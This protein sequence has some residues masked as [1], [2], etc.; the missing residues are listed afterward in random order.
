[1]IDLVFLLVFGLGLTGILAMAAAW[2]D[3]RLAARFGLR[4]GPPLLQPVYDL[5]KLAGK[6]TV[7]PAGA[8]A[9]VFLGAPLA[10]LASV[11]V[12]AS[13]LWVNV[14]FPTH[15]FLGDRVV[16]VYLLL[17]PPAAFVVGASASH[18]PLASLGA[19]REIQMLLSY[20]L[21]FVVATVVPMIKA[22]GSSRLQDIL[23]VQAAEG[24]FVRQPSGML[25]LLVF[26]ACIQAKLA[27]SPFNP[28]RA[29]RELAGGVLVEYS[30]LPLAMFWLTRQ[31]LFVALAL[32]VVAFLFGGIALS[33]VGVVVA[34]LQ[35]LA[36]LAVTSLLRRG[37]PPL[38]TEQMMRLF[39]GPVTLAAGAAVGLAL[40]GM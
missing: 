11:V 1:M 3:L 35:F 27:L 23:A 7:V 28:S 9:A 4:S 24:A 36:L 33:G 5:V 32:V 16:V 19:G 12:V 20:E 14:L 34:A 25:A 18:N 10:G 37:I 8:P 17:V 2:L 30:G 40:A 13:I 15:G 21:P 31:M 26:V 22:G 29:E 38:R 39:W 6:E